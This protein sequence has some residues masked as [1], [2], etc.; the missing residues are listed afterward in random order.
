MKSFLTVLLIA[1]SQLAVAQYSVN[2]NF[3]LAQEYSKEISL[4]KAKSFVIKEIL[5]TS[6]EVVRFEIDPLAAST[7]G[8]LTS[9]VYK[10]E[11]KKME[12]LLMGFYGNYWNDDGVIYKGY[13]FKNFPKEKALELLTKISET[14]E[15]QNAYLTED[16]DNNNIY[17]QYDDVLILIYK[18]IEPNIR[19]FWNDFDASWSLSAFKLTKKRF[20]KSIK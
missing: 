7:S 2:S 3:L 18:N 15:N 8:E 20:E 5:N 11:A 12:G 6:E 1:A 13:A 16:M 9:L 17:F 4:Y 10:C 19:V 14:I